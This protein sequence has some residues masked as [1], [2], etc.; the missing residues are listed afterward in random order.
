MKRSN[1][2]PS[3]RFSAMPMMSGCIGSTRIIIAFPVVAW[4]DIA[5]APHQD[6]WCAVWYEVRPPE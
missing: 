4:Q 6:R 2:K 5:Q 3:T 1:G